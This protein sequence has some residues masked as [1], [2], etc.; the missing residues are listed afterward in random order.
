[1][2]KAPIEVDVSPDLHSYL[3][4]LILQPRS[5]ADDHYCVTYHHYIN[6]GAI[7]LLRPLGLTRATRFIEIPI[8][9]ALRKY[10]DKSVV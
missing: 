4:Q 8:V 6:S 7:H 2:P 5:A 1:M 10:L 9:K 3:E